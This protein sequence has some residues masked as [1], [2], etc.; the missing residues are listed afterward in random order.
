MAVAYGIM[1]GA[2][3]TGAPVV[4]ATLETGVTRNASVCPESA[5]TSV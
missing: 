4:G 3:L 5:G 2:V 1:P